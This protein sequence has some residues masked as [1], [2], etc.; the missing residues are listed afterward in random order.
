MR[1]A[2]ILSL[3]IALGLT[4]AAAAQPR[5]ATGVPPTSPY[6]NLLRPGGT[7]I[8]YYGLVR[9]E[10]DF[11]RNIANFQT[12]IAATGNDNNAGEPVTGSA[13]GYQTHLRYFQ[14]GGSRGASG[15][16]AGPM[17]QNGV[18]GQPTPNPRSGRTAAPGR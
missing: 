18:R 7:G 9:P 4:S 17:I 6:L 12:Q 10:Q 5:S 11:R 15:S 14:T 2:T 16:A 3:G 1:S 13:A 8:N